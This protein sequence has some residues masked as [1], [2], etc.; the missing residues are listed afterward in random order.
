M[1]SGEQEEGWGAVHRA[2]IPLLPSGMLI[3]PDP[4]Y[5]GSLLLCGNN[6]GGT[7]G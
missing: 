5:S 6:V 3:R 4:G 1:R 2:L 7:R